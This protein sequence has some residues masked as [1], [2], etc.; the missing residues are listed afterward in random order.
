MV[1][2]ELKTELLNRLSTAN[3]SKVILFGSYA[4]GKPETDSDID[5]LIVTNDNYIPKNYKEKM[6]LYHKVSSQLIELKKKIPIDLIVHTN[7][8]HE[9]FIRL[10]SMFSKEVMKKGIILYE[11]NN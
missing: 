3:I 2:N 8:M 7:P 11:K 1:S 4:S 9:A 5:L 6:K 10:G